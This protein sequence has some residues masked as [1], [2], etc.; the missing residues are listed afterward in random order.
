M[1]TVLHSRCLIFLIFFLVSCDLFIFLFNSVASS[2]FIA[3][4]TFFFVLMWNL[5]RGIKY[6][7][8]KYIFCSFFHGFFVVVFLTYTFVFSY[9]V[10]CWFLKSFFQGISIQPLWCMSVL[11][12]RG[13]GHLLFGFFFYNMLLFFLLLVVGAL[14]I[15]SAVNSQHFSFCLKRPV[16]KRSR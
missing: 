15:F 16:S 6:L 4:V 2:V 1:F 10:N 11:S 9:L 8:F 7:S 12:G 3:A 13:P 14:N 5:F